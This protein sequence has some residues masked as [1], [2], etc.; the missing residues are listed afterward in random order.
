L[1]IAGSVGKTGAAAMAC[2]AALRMGAGL[3]TLAIPKSLNAIM[4]AKLTEVMT[5]PLPETPKQT[6]SLRAFSNIVRL[7]ENKRAVVIGPGLGTYKETQSLVLKLIRTLNLPIIL[8]ADGITALTI[9]PKTLP[10]ANRSLVLTPHPGEMAKLVRSQVKEVLEDRIGLSRNFSQSQHVHLILKGHPSLISTPKGEVFINP[11]GN[12]GMA[13]AGA[14]DVLTG[15]IGGLVCQGFDI[16]PS[17]Q[18]AVYL[19]GLA[20]DEGAKEMGEKSLIASDIIE[21][22]PA[23]LKGRI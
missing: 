23:L 22:I 5:E 18:I 10:V 19:H 17:L 15:M 11:T 12:P 9:Q 4:E 13:S 6:L 7:C 1:V 2:Q 16:L 14:G 3:V 20:G 8:D 21:K